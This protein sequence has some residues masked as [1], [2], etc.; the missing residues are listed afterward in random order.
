MILIGLLIYDHKLLFA[1]DAEN[2]GPVSESSTP[3]S[4]VLLLL[5]NRV[6]SLHS[7]EEQD[8]KLTRIDSMLIFTII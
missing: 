1:Y 4:S 8:E 3:N 5:S 2:S 6:I 7:Y